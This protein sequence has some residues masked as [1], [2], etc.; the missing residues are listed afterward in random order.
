MGSSSHLYTIFCT[1]W[2]EE[3]VARCGVRAHRAATR[4]AGGREHR[5]GAHRQ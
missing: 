3:C 5:A 4:Y 1:P 2:R